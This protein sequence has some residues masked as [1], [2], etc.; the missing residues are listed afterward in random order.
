MSQKIVT[1]KITDL[2]GVAKFIASDACKSVSI[3]TGAGV[4]CACGIPDFRSPTGLYATLPVEKVTAT[5]EQRAAIQFDRTNVIMKD[6]FMQNAFPYLEV[7]RPFILGTREKKWPATIAHR[8]FEL[9]H[10]RAGKLTRLYTQNIDGIDFQT[11]LPQEKIVPVHGSLGRAA[12]EACGRE[13]EIGPFCDKVRAQI[14]DIYGDGGPDAPAESTPI[15]CEGCGKASVKPTTVLFQG[16]L[17]DAFFE[18]A[19]EDMPGCDLLIVA[20]TSLIVGPANSLV[21][22]VPKTTLRLLINNEPVGH[23]LGIQFGTKAKR[24]VF[25]AG[26]CDDIC[27][28]L[29][30]LL[31]WREDLVA[32]ADELPPASQARLAKKRRA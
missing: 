32:M 19:D 26:D 15:L 29:I 25:A 6:L 8:F 2:A 31:G 24:D 23:E 1:A 16:Q 3:L 11:N 18:R 7:R 13:H 14:K 4:S 30:D 28:E 9:L 17:P 5:A 22:R 27:L 12:C 10:A 20:G 21:Q